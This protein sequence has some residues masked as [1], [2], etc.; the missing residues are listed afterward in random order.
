MEK[1]LIET[2]GT[3]GLLVTIFAESCL[4]FFLP[5]DTLLFTAGLLA[6]QEKL[7]VAVILI[8]SFAAAVAGNQ[9]AYALGNRVGPA[10][11]KP[12]SRLF[13]AEYVE[14]ANE[15]FDKFGSR[16]IVL[17][18][19]VPAVRTFAPILA[20]I[21]TM[22]Y[23]TFVTFNVVGALLWAVGVTLLG[24]TLGKTVHGIDK[25]LLPV[26]LVIAAVSAVP[27]LLEIRR[28]RRNR[29]PKL[30]LE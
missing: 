26:I 12:G 6:S 17:A 8:G 28:S 19:F 5:G 15:Y 7:N 24:Y 20:G 2:F 10:L 9:V 1:H 23:R 29:G 25:Y 27:V 11:F 13:K 18:R 14:R 21:G 4:I 3:I 30:P 16:T 22:R